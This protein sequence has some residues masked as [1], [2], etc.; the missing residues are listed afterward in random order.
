MMY[1]DKKLTVL[2][3]P[4]LFSRT[5]DFMDAFAKALGEFDEV[6]LLDIYPARELPIEGIDSAALL[7]K[8]QNGHKYLVQADEVCERLKNSELEIFVSLGAGDIDRL[9]QPI[10]T[11]LEQKLNEG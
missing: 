3:Q 6:L 8:I 4:H 10:K 5:R 2:F 7:K 9:V 1:P 11:T